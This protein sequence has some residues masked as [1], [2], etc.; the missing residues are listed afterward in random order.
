[1][2]QRALGGHSHEQLLE[3]AIG[4]S[5]DKHIAFLVP[6][7]AWLDVGVALRAGAQGK[8]VPFTYSRCLPSGCLAEGPL[9]PEA[10]AV[11]KSAD[12]TLLVGDRDHKVIALPISNKGFDDAQKSLEAQSSS[13]TGLMAR[14]RH[15]F[16]GSA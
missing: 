6:L 1:M 8:A 16:G 4:A 3:V 15:M 2:S 9:T 12:A 7:G 11:L 14:V 5:K 10:I 13:G